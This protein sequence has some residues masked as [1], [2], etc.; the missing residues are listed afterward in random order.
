MNEVHTYQNEVNPYLDLPDSMRELET[1]RPSMALARRAL[2]GY[3]LF[4]LED[5]PFKPRY[6]TFIAL[7]YAYAR[8]NLVWKDDGDA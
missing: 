7:G 4:G 5:R 3:E 1:F 2:A 8:G 6:R